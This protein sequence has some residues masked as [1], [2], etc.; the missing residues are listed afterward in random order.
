MSLKGI[1]VSMH[2]AGINLSAVSADFVIVKATEGTGYT[3]PQ[4]KNLI[5]QAIN[6]GKRIGVYHF[7]RNDL[8]NLGNTAIG[9]ADWFLSVVKDYIGKAILILDWESKK[10]GEV[11]YAKV[12]LDRVYSKTGIRPMI[13]MNQSTENSY[14]WSAVAKENYGLWGAKYLDNEADK[15]YDMSNAGTPFTSKF[16]N[17]VA[18]WQWTSSGIL[19]GWPHNLDCSIFYGDGAAWDKYA[20]GSAPAP[21][22][23]PVSFAVGDTVC[24]LR[25]VS[26]E[27]VSLIATVLQHTYPVIE[28]KGDRVVLGGGLNTAMCASNLT[29]VRTGVTSAIGVGSRVRIRNGAKDY[30]GTALAAF[31]YS[32]VYTVQEVNGK[33]AVLKE[34][35]TAVSTDNL[36]LA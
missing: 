36:Y 15:N 29:K 16:W 31:V 35:Q 10:P 33:R 18:M 28:V 6:A 4:F 32:N 17:V 30:N 26:Y 2:Q 27:G 12:W 1:D 20:G 19:D 13:Y 11:S 9:E 34:I 24:P 14:D 21:I 22:P 8:Q 7:C 3:D 5:T 23:Q 25:N